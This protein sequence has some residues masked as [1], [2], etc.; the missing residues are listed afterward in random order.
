MSSRQHLDRLERLI[1]GRAVDGSQFKAIL[2]DEDSPPGGLKVEAQPSF[3]GR[4]VSERVHQLR[5]HPDFQIARRAVILSRLAQAISERQAQSG[6][7]RVL[8][9]QAKRLQ[10]PSARRCEAL[11]GAASMA[12]EVEAEAEDVLQQAKSCL[13]S[14][15]SNTARAL[16]GRQVYWRV[17]GRPGRQA[18]LLGRDGQNRDQTIA[19]LYVSLD[20]IGG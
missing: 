13:R 11:G 8:L 2:N 5:S 7:G 3:R 12:L 14:T 1:T 17:E 19:R 10:W 15:S 6:P 9:R 20:E 18:W 4:I 16:V